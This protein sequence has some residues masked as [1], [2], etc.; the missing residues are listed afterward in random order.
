MRQDQKYRGMALKQKRKLLKVKIGYGNRGKFTVLP[1]LMSIP[2]RM[3]PTR[4]SVPN[5]ISTAWE[6]SPF[7]YWGWG[8]REGGHTERD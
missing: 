4:K 8:G 2:M 7:W 5:N 3:A 1:V 6:F